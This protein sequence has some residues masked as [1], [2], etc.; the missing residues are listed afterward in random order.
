MHACPAHLAPLALR[1]ALL[2]PPQRTVQRVQALARCLPQTVQLEPMRRRQLRAPHAFQGLT[3]ARW[4]QDLLLLV[5]RAPPE[6]GVLLGLPVL[7][8]PVKCAVWVL[9]VQ[10]WVQTAAPHA[11]N[12]LWADF[13]QA[14]EPL[15]CPFV[16]LVRR[17]FP[18]PLAP[19]SPR[20]K[21]AVARLYRHTHS[22]CNTMPS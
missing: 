13:H 9:I 14:Q 12:A 2:V 15:I 1:P 8:L 5:P 6:R 4:G 10:R 19:S 16:C 11:S 7:R 21:L 18:A 17:V 20:C 3:A 22:L